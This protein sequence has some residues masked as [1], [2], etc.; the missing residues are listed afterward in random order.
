MDLVQ[1]FPSDAEMQAASDRAQQTFKYFWRELTWEYRRIVP[2]CAVKMVKIGFPTGRPADPGPSHE[3][4][5]VDRIDFDGLRVYGTL[6]NQPNWIAGLNEGDAVDVPLA[7]VSDWIYSRDDQVFGGFTVHLIRSRMGA[8][9]Q[10]SHDEAWGYD[11]S[12]PPQLAPGSPDDEHPMS[13]NMAPVYR[14]QLAGDTSPARFVDQNGWTQL[15]HFAL[16][17]SHAIVDVLL[18]A[19]ADPSAK[20]PDGR[21]ARDL[22]VAMGWPRVVARLD[23]G[24]A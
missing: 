10:R 7:Q 17:G 24:R 19:G 14:D 15:H 9:E 13:E 8:A 16:G 6:N 23:V 11:F 12:G 1:M 2:G 3:H 21:T 18:H 5:W 20:T 4:M 22:A